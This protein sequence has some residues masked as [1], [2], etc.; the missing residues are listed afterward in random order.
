MENK[1]AITAK[2]EAI[3]NSLEGVQKASP[4]PFFFTRV[5]AR[6]QKEE[7]TL[8]GR[9]AGFITKP[10]VA[11]ATLFL[12]FLLNAAALFYQQKTSV[13]VA[14]QVEQGNIEEYNTTLAANS[15]YDENTD[16][17]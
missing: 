7:I 10:A 11:L 4:A 16:A 13:S 14:D 6:L 5:Q 12:I 17:R 3:L 1:Q 9:F 2:T 15:Y 8:W